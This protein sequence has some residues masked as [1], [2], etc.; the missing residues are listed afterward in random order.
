MLSHLKTFFQWN[1]CRLPPI[2]MGAMD[3]SLQVTS[4]TDKVP[5]GSRWRKQKDYHNEVNAHL[6]RPWR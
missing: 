6:T 3:E 1:L 5:L 2:Q 4:K